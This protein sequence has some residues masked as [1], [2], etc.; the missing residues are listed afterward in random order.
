MWLRTGQFR[1][2]EPRFPSSGFHDNRKRKHAY[3][4]NGIVLIYF[5]VRLLNDTLSASTFIYSQ[6]CFLY[7]PSKHNNF[8]ATNLHYMCKWVY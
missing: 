6:I 8:E 1:F 3:V 5:L 2:V 4:I 7:R